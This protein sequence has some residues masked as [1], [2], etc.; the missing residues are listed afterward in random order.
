MIN[1]PIGSLILA[2]VSGFSASHAATLANFDFTAGSLSNA[3]SPAVGITISS[4]TSNSAFNLFT[5]NS[6]WDSAAQISGASGFFSIPTTQ[7]AAQNAVSFTV[8][9]ESGY[10]FS[11]D[12]LSFMARSTSTAPGDIGFKINSAS[13]DFSNSYSNNS[14]ITSIANSSLGLTHLTSATI[15][16]QGWNSNG[17]GA[18]QLDNIVLTGTVMA[19][20]PSISIPEP[21]SVVLCMSGALALWRRRR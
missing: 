8:T 18:L 3:A 17:S 11:L 19:P 1:A 7:A 15:S 9:A 13:Y 20:P 14:A 6:G 10:R 12:G 2:F 4:L 16:I 5:S 21:S